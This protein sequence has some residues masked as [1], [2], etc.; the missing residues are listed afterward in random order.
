[1]N[2]NFLALISLLLLGEMI[3]FFFLL[4]YT[5][6]IVIRLWFVK[7][8]KFLFELTEGELKRIRER[9]GVADHRQGIH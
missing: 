5:C 6:E 3:L 2:Y 7:Y 9:A 1:M 8:K 4:M